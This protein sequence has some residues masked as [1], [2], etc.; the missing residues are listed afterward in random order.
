MGAASRVF[1]VNPPFRR[2]LSTIVSRGTPVT[3][4]AMPDPRAEIVRRLLDPGLIAV[5]RAKA[6]AQV[7]PLAAALV[8]GGIIAIEVTTTTPDHLRAIREAKAALGPAAVVG[9]G[10]VLEAATCR[11][12]LE[13]G[14]EFVVSPIAR[15]ELVPL[16]H[17]AGRPVM[18]GACTPTECQLV[19]ESGA[20]FVKLFPADGLGPGFVKAL[21]APLPHL[22]LV[23]TGGVDLDTAADFLK[24]GCVALGVGSSLLK[25]DILSRHDWPALTKLAAEFVRVVRAARG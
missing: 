5:V 20:D 13:A 18:L 21:R 11:A 17:A 2:V 14:A 22:R 24:A 8:A 7:P 19:H 23:P 25:P 15:T 4:D 1:V 9:V 3:L 6:P 12:A 16:C 10:T